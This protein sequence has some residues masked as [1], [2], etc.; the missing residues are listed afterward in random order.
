MGRGQLLIG[1][2]VYIGRNCR[3]FVRDSCKIGRFTLFADNVSVYD[4][5]HIYADEKPIGQQGFRTKAIEIEENC[6]LCTN[7]VVTMGAEIGRKVVVG[8]NAVVGGKLIDGGVYASG[9]AE[10][11]RI[12][13]KENDQVI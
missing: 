13:G 12:S 5:N 2:K 10:L 3:I 11:I 8:A 9:R 1:E 7:V 6:W 4:H